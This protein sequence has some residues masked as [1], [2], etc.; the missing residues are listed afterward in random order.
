ML[1]AGC[2][3]NFLSLRQCA[4][5]LPLIV[6][7]LSELASTG[8]LLLDDTLRWRLLGKAAAFGTH[9]ACIPSEDEKE[10]DN[11]LNVFF[12]GS[13][14]PELLGTLPR[15]EPS[16][17]DPALCLNAIAIG[18]QWLTALAQEKLS[19]MG[20]YESN[21]S[22]RA[23]LESLLPIL[24][25]TKGA[26]HLFSMLSRELFAKPISIDEPTEKLLRHAGSLALHTSTVEVNFVPTN[27][28]RV[29]I[30]LFRE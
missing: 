22:I 6:E 30:D 7:M 1:I 28:T 10:D 26:C 23:R 18:S 4:Q 15:I 29:L 25:E 12:P 9:W 27:S 14:L 24:S 2:T 19:W 11:S 16:Q 17:Q 20:I 8:K 21:P 13:R 3:G 5:Q